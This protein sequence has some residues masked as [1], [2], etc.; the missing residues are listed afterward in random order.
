[1]LTCFAGTFCNG[2]TIL[3]NIIGIGN[4]TYTRL[5]KLCGFLKAICYGEAFLFISFYNML[6]P[7]KKGRESWGGG[8]TGLLPLSLLQR[9][10]LHLHVLFP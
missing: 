7:G 8:A 1:M 6:P 3:V 2:I 5:D 10:V 9:L 4:E